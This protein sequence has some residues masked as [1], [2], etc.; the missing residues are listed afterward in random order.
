MAHPRL[1]LILRRRFLNRRGLHGFLVCRHS[2][3]PFGSL[4]WFV[5][6]R[7]HGHLCRSL[8]VLMMLLMLLLFLMLMVWLVWLTLL[9]LMTS[10]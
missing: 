10:V 1:I 9:M 5:P 7:C 3:P 6:L 2:S 4:A 8:M